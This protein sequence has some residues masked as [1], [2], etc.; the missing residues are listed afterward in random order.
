MDMSVDTAERLEQAEASMSRMLERVNAET[1]EVEKAVE[2]L[3]AA[4]AGLSED[5]LVKLREGGIV[6]QGA[7]VGALLFFTR[8]VSETV[9][10]VGPD[11]GS[12]AVPALIQGAL[13]LA[14][15]AFFFLF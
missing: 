14:L 13:A 4:Q 6:K 11:G 12:H 5:P 1:K 2:D 15:A 8:A 3:K 10:M 7:L 9:A